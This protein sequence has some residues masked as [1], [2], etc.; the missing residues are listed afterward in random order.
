[1]ARVEI[2]TFIRNTPEVVFDLSRS[3]D[4]HI[5][6]TAGTRE[7]A[8]AG[9]TSGLIGLNESVTWQARHLFK[10]R[11]FTSVITAFEFPFS[12]TDEMT[13]GDLK[14]FSHRHSFEKTEAG[15]LMKDELILEAP[16]GFLGKTIMAVFLKNYFRRLL[17][18]RNAVIK[19]YA[20]NGKAEMILKYNSR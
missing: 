20:E 14:S 18:E 9:I 13:K 8:V 16:F 3:I 12:F 17:C 5:I 7:K 6:S 11:S 4:L 15:T 19:A 1:M 10:T 2:I